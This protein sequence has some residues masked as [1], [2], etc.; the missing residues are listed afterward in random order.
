MLGAATTAGGGHGGD[1]ATTSR[2]DGALAA[3]GRGP[4]AAVRRA[5]LRPLQGLVGRAPGAPL[6]G[7]GAGPAALPRAAR[8]DAAAA[9]WQHHADRPCGGL[10]ARRVC[11][12]DQAPAGLDLWCGAAA[13]LDADLLPPSRALPKPAAPELAPPQGPGDAA[14]RAAGPPA[15]GGGAD[16][17]GPVQDRHAGPGGAGRGG[18][19]LCAQLQRPAAG[20]R[21]GAAH[22]AAAGR[23]APGADPRHAPCPCGPLAPAP[24]AGRGCVARFHSRSGDR[25]CNGHGNGA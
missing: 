11:A 6:A 2:R 1:V 23:A 22:P 5:A 17:H 10:G 24:R 21:G 8:P 18:R 16:G 13:A 19:A 4:G 14:G 20:A 3:A 15:F 9:R 7:A 12:G 25:A